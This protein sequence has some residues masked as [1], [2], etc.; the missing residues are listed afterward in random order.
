MTG[1]S[2]PSQALLVELQALIDA[3]HRGDIRAD[4][5][6]RLERLLRN[7]Q[8]RD[9]YL[10]LVWESDVLA[11]WVKVSEQE[12]LTA[13]RRPRRSTVLGF[14][15]STLRGAGQAVARHPVA[16][17]SLALVAAVPLIAWL[18]SP[19]VPPQVAAGEG[20]NPPARAIA[21]HPGLATSDET[22]ADE[23]ADEEEADEES[24]PLPPS[25]RRVANPVAREARTIDCV[26]ARELDAPEAGDDLAPGQTL[27][28]KSG[29]AEI[30]FKNGAC[31]I[32]QGP[33]VLEVRS[34]SS[35]VANLGKCTATVE[36]PQ[37]RGFEIDAPG[38]KYI[39][40]G[41]EFGVAVAENGV[42]EIHVFRGKVEAEQ[43]DDAE[44]GRQEEGE[45][46]RR[47][48]GENKS[49]SSSI[50]RHPS[51]LLLTANQALRVTAPAAADKPAPIE[52]IA[53]NERQFVR[54]LPPA[55]ALDL[56][57]VVAGGDGLS[58]RRNR[59]I[60]PTNGRY[61]DE[62]SGRDNI[63]AGP[64]TVFKADEQY[65]RVPS[66]A[67]IDGVF[68]VQG[69]KGAVQL[70]SAGHR[71]AGFPG[72]DGKTANMI[73]AVGATPSHPR[74]WF[75][76]KQNNVP[77]LSGVDYSSIGHGLLATRSNKGITFDL[78]AI[79]AAHSGYRLL[80]LT[81]VVG[82]AC[83]Q[84]TDWK[85]GNFWVFV[86]GQ[87]RFQRRNVSGDAG[88][89]PL[90]VPLEPADRY[91]TLVATTTTAAGIWNGTMFGDPKL[92]ITAIERS[93]P[94]SNQE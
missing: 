25:K 27:N 66:S 23:I 86:D 39:D 58:T 46:G 6:K 14:L 59:E 73:Q 18:A 79:R 44:K 38:M 20:G 9:L 65:H 42:H 62:P 31:A 81:A 63:A 78:A 85:S 87:L 35:A 68:I 4:Q 34:R 28:L 77:Q 52:R 67:L 84:S 10:E 49:N 5:M 1:R 24:S 29:L 80:S 43:R 89:I 8:A 64:G 19:P 36:N 93:P 17:A 41:T 94:D 83:R 7:P 82:N 50:V 11:T 72:N 57:D 15:H 75:T 12:R 32:L 51:S 54:A 21:S 91:L 45:K 30:V 76:D 13:V 74:A 92:N 56:V 88:A 26:W 71:F 53:A 90:E 48:E 40:L 16:A 55:T 47:G 61:S 70:D 69:G 33:A 3:A 37:A 60:N 22:Q 2:I